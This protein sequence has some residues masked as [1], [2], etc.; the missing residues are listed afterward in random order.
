SK[1]Y[2]I[3][4]EKSALIKKVHV[5]P[6]RQVK[7][8]D[9]LVELTSNELEI[10]I[11]K[12]TNR[13]SVLRSEQ[14]EK[15]KLIASEIEYAKAEHGI[16][17]EEIDTDIG[18]IKSK[19]ELNRS[20]TREFGSGTDTTAVSLAKNPQQIK[21]RSLHQQKQ[22]HD[23]ALQIKIE[24]IRQENTT[25]QSL[26]VNQ[27]KLL[28]RELELLIEEKKKLSKF[29]ATGGVVE[30]VYVKDGEQVDAFTPLLSVNPVRPST[31][32][33]YLVGKKVNIPTIGSSVTI[34]S[35]DLRSVSV[36][37]KVIGYGSVSELPE[38]LQKSTAVK[39]F[40][41]EIYIEISPENNFASGEKVLIR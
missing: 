39:A 18:Q 14:H 5:V 7:A 25:E 20:I 30:N 34:S 38:I 21:L 2:K 37:G 4:S 31:V 16:T 17:I 22:K 9:I 28:E 26:L 27:I 24:D 41:R 6:G 8:G 35:Y 33:G 36:M 15:S 11:D 13:I 40:G 19:L 29:A 1:E 12:L 10:D 23:R 3:N 32:V